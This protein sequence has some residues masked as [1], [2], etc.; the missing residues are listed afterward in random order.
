MGTT[1][2]YDELFELVK[3]SLISENRESAEPLLDLYL[4]CTDYDFCHEPDSKFILNLVALA[5][6]YNER[7]ICFHM[8][9]LVGCGYSHHDTAYS[10][11]EIA[12]WTSH[13]SIP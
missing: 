12:N 4:L 8:G 7:E 10:M 1:W 9:K 3:F 2:Q 13:Y 5:H 6:A 11:N